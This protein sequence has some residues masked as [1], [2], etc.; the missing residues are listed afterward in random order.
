[1]QAQR[2]EVMSD[3]GSGMPNPFVLTWTHMLCMA[4]FALYHNTVIGGAIRSTLNA[5]FLIPVRLPNPFII[6]WFSEMLWSST[7]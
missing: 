2:K 6:V 1:M 7:I 4:P 5:D 3:M